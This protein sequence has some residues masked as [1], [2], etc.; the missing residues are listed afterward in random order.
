[1][2]AQT[3][4]NNHVPCQLYSNSQGIFDGGKPRLVAAETDMNY[5]RART[6]DMS[7]SPIYPYKMLVVLW[8][9]ALSRMDYDTREVFVSWCL[10]HSLDEQI[11]CSDRASTAAPLGKSHVAPLN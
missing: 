3:S 1:M 11:G 7:D 6:V 9:H 8:D 5:S 4:G 10:P 2:S